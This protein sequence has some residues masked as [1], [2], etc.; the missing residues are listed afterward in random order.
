MNNIEKKAELKK[1]INCVLEKAYIKSNE[2][3]VKE[4]NELLHDIAEDM[5]TILVLGEFK[6][7]KSTF[8]NSLLKENLLPSDVLPETAVISAIGYNP[9]AYAEVLYEDGTVIQGEPTLDFL[10]NFSA[11]G[12]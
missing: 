5:F 7:G 9:H 2:K 4:L 1:T 3:V 11:R 10:S 6:R 8:I 12:R